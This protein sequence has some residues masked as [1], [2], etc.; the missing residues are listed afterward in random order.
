[1]KIVI[2]KGLDIPILGRP[3]G[4]IS[5]LPPPSLVSL[6]LAPFSEIGFKLLVKEGAQVK[7]GQPLAE[8]KAV[9]GQMYVSP[10]CGTVSEIRRGQKRQLL[11]IVIAVAQK[12]EYEEHGPLSLRETSKEQILQ[13]LLQGGIFPHIRMR[14]F[15]LVATP[16]L[17]PKHIFV[18]AL[19]SV[20]LAP[21]AEMHVEGE[22]ESFQAGLD[23]LA[24]LTEGRVHLVFRDKTACRAFSDA[25]GALKHTVVGPH[26]AGNPSLHIHRVHPIKNAQEIIWTLSAPDVV[27]L[28]KMVSQ[29]RYYTKRIVAV[30]GSGVQEGKRGFFAARAGLPLSSFASFLISETP[31][32]LISGD[33]LSGSSA[34]EEDFLGFYHNC[35]SA[36]PQNTERKWMP[37]MRLSSK[38]FSS[39]RTYFSLPFRM[40]Y[41]FTTNQHGE[42]RPFIDG[43]VYQK[44]MALRIPVMELTRAVLA[45][46]FELAETLGLL[47]VAPEDFAL[48]AFICPSKIDFM[49]IIRRGLRQYA[50]E[51]GF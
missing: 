43:S 21:P 7:I 32:Q 44:A 31:L 6:N 48:P 33:P 16:R 9:P 46:N 18:S 38:N 50:H 12:E 51:L 34:K 13:R 36:I 30:A 27:T 20:P 10:A 39:F 1:M 2:K 37:F 23:A 41:S 25:R 8:N 40:G 28:G 35:F 5:P 19:T 24:K 22:E 17:L 3:E 42:G 29:G 26:P 11:D 45:E 14:P 49:E 15:D 47:E 4:K